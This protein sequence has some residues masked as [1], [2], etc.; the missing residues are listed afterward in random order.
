MN[1]C[2]PGEGM[3]CWLH[4]VVVLLSVL[5]EKRLYGVC[6]SL[7]QQ[8]AW[9]PARLHAALH[10]GLCVG[11]PTARAPCALCQQGVR[12]V[13]LGRCQAAFRGECCHQGVSS[14]A[15]HTLLA[16]GPSLSSKAVVSVALTAD[17][18]CMPACPVLQVPRIGAPWGCWHHSSGPEA[19]QAHPGYRCIWGPVFLVR[20]Q[21]QL[22][23]VGGVAGQVPECDV[24]ASEVCAAKTCL[25]V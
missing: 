12:D 13:I 18:A 8:C 2:F 24:L 16:P 22:G 10:F 6:G 3:T 17:S 21:V 9:L 19:R 23:G 15:T 14:L 20:S 7:C 4:S 11:W 1:G 25:C 5:S